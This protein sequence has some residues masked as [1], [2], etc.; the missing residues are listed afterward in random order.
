[1]RIS[2][3]MKPEL[4]W[5]ESEKHALKKANEMVCNKSCNLRFKWNPAEM[6]YFCLN[7]KQL[8]RLSNKQAYSSVFSSI[9]SPSNDTNRI[10]STAPK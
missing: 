4:L 10:D 8:N 9:L 2:T 7:I 1:M 6:L 3:G 5:A